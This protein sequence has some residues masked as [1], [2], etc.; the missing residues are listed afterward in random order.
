MKR[1]FYDIINNTEYNTDVINLTSKD[2][3]NL[4]ELGIVCDFET[5]G[6]C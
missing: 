2:Y 1:P 3:P 5:I 6:S 4:N